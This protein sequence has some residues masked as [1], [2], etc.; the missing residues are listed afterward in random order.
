MFEDVR[1]QMFQWVS[2]LPVIL[3]LCARGKLKALASS[4]QESGW[5]LRM[6]RE[7]PT[8]AASGQ[9]HDGMIILQR[10]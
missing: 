2:S 1:F 3:K 10:M 9:A 6:K 5:N 7:G 8:Q 4:C